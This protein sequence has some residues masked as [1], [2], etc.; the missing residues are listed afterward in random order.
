MYLITGLDFVFSPTFETMESAIADV[1]TQPDGTAWDVT[2][3]VDT[4]QGP[5]GWPAITVSSESLAELQAWLKSVYDD[6][7]G[8]YA[9][10]IVQ[11]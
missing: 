11:R 6:E 3:A 10:G 7:D 4:M 9:R 8:W 5:T 1:S 2:I